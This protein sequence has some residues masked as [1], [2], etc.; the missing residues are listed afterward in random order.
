MHAHNIFVDGHYN[1]DSH[2]G[3]ILLLNDGRVG[4]ID[5]GQARTVALQDRAVMARIL[6]A[7]A[8][9]D[10]ASAVALFR[11]AGYTTTHSNDDLC[12]RI[13]SIAMDRDDREITRGVDLQSFMEAQ[14]KEDPVI[15]MADELI[16]PG[17][18]ALL[19]RGV[20]IALGRPMSVALAW[21]TQAERFLQQH[22][23][24]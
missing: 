5:W 11:A 9:G 16:M 8:A 24:A 14:A 7:L 13:A 12:W 4:L 2:P 6:L 23:D 3:N 22:P 18:C 1:G 19:L 20:A 15:K 10:R 17:R 21:R